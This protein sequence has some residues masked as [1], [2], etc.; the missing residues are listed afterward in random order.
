MPFRVLPD[1]RVLICA[2]AAGALT[3]TS[4]ACGPETSTPAPQQPSTALAADPE[5]VVWADQVCQA[6]QGQAGKLSTLPALDSAEPRRLKQGMITYLDTL[7]EA[8]GDLVARIEAT[9]PPP[10]ANGEA[11]LSRTTTT[12]RDTKESIETARGTANEASTEDPAAFQATM[13]A[14]G[15]D[16]GELHRMEDPTGDL[17]ADPALGKAFA[18]AATCKQIEGA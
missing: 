6:I 8:F 13:T 7:S 11:L 4:A 18:E 14:V 3:L 10:V 16:M 17:K 1:V 9:G 5:A 15:E 2:V 12:L